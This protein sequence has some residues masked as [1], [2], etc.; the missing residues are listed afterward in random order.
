[1]RLNLR[2]IEVFRAIMVTGS[3]SGAAKLLNVSQ[4]AVS[5][6]LSYVEQR[7][8]L[9]LFE[10]IKGRLYPTPE[11]R[12]LLE[13]VN[14]VYQSVQRV[15]EVAEDLIQHR[16]SHLRIGCSL[17]LGQSL[18]PLVI[19]AFARDFPDVR[20][21]LHT[22]SP[23]LV[24]QA[25]LTQQIEL[26]VA[27]M[28]ASHPNLCEER[29][30]EN[31][32]VA[33]MPADHPLAARERLQVADLAGEAFIGYS[34]DIPFGDLV[35]QLFDSA[36]HS[37][38]P[39][40]EVQQVHVACALVEAGLGIALVDEQTVAHGTWQRLITRPLEQ[41][42]SAPVQVFHRLYEPLSRTAQAFVGTLRAFR[43]QRF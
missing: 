7:L 6:L 26:G 8:R 39:R 20:V 41:T 19:A 30:Y 43:D 33:A 36:E 42:I 1:M 34:S 31:C 9:T 3:I 13:E 25:L 27:Y 35:G 18:L 14:V 10:R 11:A 28:P 38:E 40:I 37:P 21:I 17:N 2:Q 12:R 5:R 29:L 23:N 4:P 16:A 32:I 24:I 15:N 22:T